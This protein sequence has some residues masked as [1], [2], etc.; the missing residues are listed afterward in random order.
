MC[1][2][3][4]GGPCVDAA[5]LQCGCSEQAAKQAITACSQQ[6][7]VFM[8]LC[9]VSFVSLSDKMQPRVWLPTRL[10][11]RS[12]HCSAPAGAKRRTCITWYHAC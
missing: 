5:Q 7:L 8:N 11:R 3:S 12:G 9:C 6:L 2:A 1:V 4:P 10:G